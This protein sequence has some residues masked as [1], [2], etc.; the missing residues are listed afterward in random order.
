[1]QQHTAELHYTRCCKRE[2]EPAFT[3]MGESLATS[4][5]LT[6][7]FR[8][9]VFHK[10]WLA[11]LSF[12]HIQF[13]CFLQHTSRSTVSEIAHTHTPVMHTSMFAQQKMR[14]DL[15]G[16][17]SRKSN[18]VHHTVPSSVTPSTVRIQGYHRSQQ[19]P[20]ESLSEAGQA[21]APSIC[22]GTPPAE[23]T[24]LSQANFISLSS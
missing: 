9:P 7:V 18:R 23:E 8:V 24:P 14:R 15:E 21:F 10:P 13:C 12:Y 4:D 3:L 16:I 20:T 1:M 22:A 6:D 17:C 11:K 5:I 2:A 19:D